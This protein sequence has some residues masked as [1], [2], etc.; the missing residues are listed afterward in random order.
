[1]APHI[2]NYDEW[3]SQLF[4]RLR[5]RM[6]STAEP[7]LNTLYD[8]LQSYPAPESSRRAGRGAHSSDSVFT[9]LVLAFDAQ[10]ISLLTTSTVFVTAEDVTLSEIALECFYPADDASATLLRV[11]FESA[12]DGKAG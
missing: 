3:R 5:A 11:R 7:A 10:V 2:V 8:E 6:E 9:A 1:M 4:R 12:R